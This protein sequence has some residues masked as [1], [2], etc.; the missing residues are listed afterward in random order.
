MS[1]SSSG[2]FSSS[3]RP[4]LSAVSS[5]RHMSAAGRRR[6]ECPR[7][8]PATPPACSVWRAADTGAPRLGPDR[9]DRNH[10]ADRTPDALERVAGDGDPPAARVARPYV[11]T[12]ILP[13]TERH[14][15][16]PQRREQ[17]E[18]HRKR[19]WAEQPDGVDS[20]EHAPEL[21]RRLAHR[22]QHLDRLGQR[23][24]VLEF[25]EL[26]LRRKLVVRL[27]RLGVD[28]ADDRQPIDMS[29]QFD[30]EQRKRAFGIQAPVR[31]PVPIVGVDG[32]APTARAHPRAPGRQARP[33][34][35]ATARAGNPSRMHPAAK[36]MP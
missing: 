28:L 24:E 35:A 31:S 17:R 27:A 29:C 33:R 23:G 9:D 30:Q 34:H 15:P 8:A 6:G 22:T 2:F 25:G 3:K 7:R 21:D 10:P 20:V 5:V 12:K 32:E 16:A 11:A 13:D 14:R 36:P 19:V 18:H 1:A 4:T 26:D